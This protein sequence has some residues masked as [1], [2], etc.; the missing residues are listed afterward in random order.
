MAFLEFRDRLVDV[1]PLFGGDVA[2]AVAAGHNAEDAGDLVG[3]AAAFASLLPHADPRVPA[4]ARLHLGRIAWKQSRVDEALEHCVEARDIAIRLGDQDL[5]ARVENAMGVLHIARSEYA[6][7]KA[8]YG[9]ALELTSDVVT[10]GKIALNLGVIANIQGV[11]D[12]ARRHYAQSLTLFR[13]ANNDAGISL[14]LHNIG[15]FHADMAEW[16]EADEAFRESLMLFER[17]G[18]RQMIG[19]VLENRSEVTYGRG[20]IQEGLAQSEMALEVYAEIGDERGRGWALRWRAHGLRLLGRFG[21]AINSLNESIR[22]AQRTQTRLMEAEAARELG[23]VYRADNRPREARGAFT[24][25]LSIFTAL[26]ARRDVADLE[27]EL[28]RLG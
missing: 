9:M 13:E 23:Y 8:A 2:D 20:R 10:R 7:A 12:L 1:A 11:F 3:A 19:Q 21:A 18:N 16:D 14:A 6:Q 25:A 24:R 5:R 4:E 28:A 17:L 15:M 22:I 26:D 27:G